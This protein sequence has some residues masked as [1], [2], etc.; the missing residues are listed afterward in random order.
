MILAPSAAASVFRQAAVVEMPLLGVS[1]P[2]PPNLR[3]LL[4]VGDFFLGG[5]PR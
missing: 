3:S 5:E 4:L 2:L 1:G